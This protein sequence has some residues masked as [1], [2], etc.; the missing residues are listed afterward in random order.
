MTEVTMF[1]IADFQIDL[2]RSVVIKGD[3]QTQVE[4]KVLKVL[5]LL[6][7][8]QNEVVTHKEIMEH[9]WQG[10]EVVPNALQRCIAIL[11]KVLCDDA[12]APSIIATHPRIGYSLLA[13]VRWQA[14]P[15]AS[16]AELVADTQV[17]LKK[18]NAKFALVLILTFTLLLLVLLINAFGESALPS[19]YTQ[20]KQLTQTDAHETYAL[21]SPQAKY[22][23]FNRYAGACKSHLW[24]R[25]V[26]SG[27]EQQ[28]TAQAG[29]FGGVSF[30]G[31]GR[32]LVFAAKNYCGNETN[33]NQALDTRQQECWSI[34]TVDF[35]NALSAP[36]QPSFRYQCQ[37]ERLENPKALSNHQ[38]AYLQYEGGRY[39]LMHYDDLSK[40]LTSLYF[41]AQEYIYHFDYD[42][43]HKRFVVISRDKQ[44]NTQVTLLDENGQQLS[45]NQIKFTKG[46]SRNQYF[47]ANFEPQGNYLLATSNNK[48]VKIDF[49]GQLQ[50]LK[51]P[52]AN[53]VSVVKHPQ[54]HHLL[55][56]K[57]KK[58]VDIANI[59]LE[60]NSET[61]AEQELA[62]ANF[63][64]A[65]TTA[66]NKA[67]LNGTE[68]N[69]TM[70][71]FDS[72][73][74]TAAQERYAQFQPNGDNIA[75]IS[76]RS[77]QDQLWL[78]TPLPEQGQ[79]QA[80]QL[81]FE[82][83]QDKI[84][85]Y[86]WSPDG[87][88]L[89][90]VSADKLAIANLKGEVQFIDTNKPLYSVLAWY[91][92]NQFIVLLNDPEPGGLYHL[93]IEHNKLTPFGINQVE[94]AWVNNSQLIYSNLTG[95]VFSRTL[96]ID[97]RTTQ[98]LAALNGKAMLVKNGFIYSVDKH[99]FMLNQYDLNGQL[100][101]AIAPL[102]ATAWKITDLNNNQLLLDQFIAINNE[103]V[104]LQ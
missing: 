12:K 22:Q 80:V 48:L 100:I 38:Y 69:S 54:H 9:V 57:G 82:S 93:D 65:K 2:S 47:S 71:P 25:H 20:V 32:E 79:S 90:W 50:P 29:Y 42:N 53:L 63:R 99:N 55:A 76:D 10:T 95:E 101:K 33:N 17:K 23:V 24:A 37:A 8:R 58:D 1:Y 26:D 83:S 94:S 96:D 21:Y 67:D 27:K 62:T 44:F 64:D 6:A 31:D 39:Q 49:D 40:A 13:D 97:N 52:E 88:H 73:A 3:E 15:D 43:L 5:L 81:S 91:R 51:T 87:K 89:A 14:L 11:R 18:T 28:L 35:A 41:S 4:P 75:F 103:I 85:N 16:Q 102:K 19:Q 104:L 46:M 34:A 66:S 84:H 77:G 60:V 30:T 36:Q 74:R 92:K 98:Q 70:L 86:S 61:P 72:L 7:Q 45:K 78:W 59:T 68:L 56:I